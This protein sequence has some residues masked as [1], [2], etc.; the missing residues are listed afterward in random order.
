MG[1]YTASVIANIMA[2][3]GAGNQTHQLQEIK[4][5]NQPRW[6]CFYKHHE[7]TGS[8]RKTISDIV[9]KRYIVQYLKARQKNWG[10]LYRTADWCISKVSKASR[11]KY[12]PHATIMK[13]VYGMAYF[14]QTHHLR[15]RV[16][17]DRADQC[18][19]CSLPETGIFHMGK[20][21]GEKQQETR[22][23][24]SA[25][26]QDV[27][28]KSS[29]TTE[30]RNSLA[31]FELLDPDDVWNNYLSGEAML[32]ADGTANFAKTVMEMGEESYRKGVWDKKM[33]GA[34]RQLGVPQEEAQSMSQ[35]LIRLHQQEI[36]ILYNNRCKQAH[37]NAQ[38]KIAKIA[39][40]RKRKVHIL[41]SKKR[42]RKKRVE[43]LGPRRGRIDS[44]FNAK[45]VSDP[46]LV[47]D[48]VPKKNTDESTGIS[49]NYDNITS[50][51][52]LDE[53]ASELQVDAASSNYSGV[54]NE[55][56]PQSGRADSMQEIWREDCQINDSDM[57]SSKQGNTD[58]VSTTC[59]F[60]DPI[61]FSPADLDDVERNVAPTNKS[62]KD[63]SDFEAASKPTC[64][65]LTAEQRQRQ[66]TR[67]QSTSEGKQKTG[68]HSVKGHLM[69]WSGS[70]EK[71][72]DH[73]LETERAT[74][75]AKGKKRR[76]LANS[77]DGLQ[78]NETHNVAEKGSSTANGFQD[79][80]PRK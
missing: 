22:I 4:L 52:S 47:N 63:V 25:R 34:I 75:E 68:L 49:E 41:P 45:M 53:N 62:V 6:R 38:K 11:P 65:D 33:V 59:G 19:F 37:A 66:E 80:V 5:W 17:A 42:K 76:R 24:M 55:E 56:L 73:I 69:H 46:M 20:C 70:F 12:S 2:D 50:D 58:T 36:S 28:L 74:Y 10:S 27:W 31:D 78:L 7:I 15:G 60:Q 67:Q 16:D 43:P 23:L 9:R 26:K 18:P 48:I 39:K 14:R 21:S 1:E 32:V 44:F 40:R 72:Q 64:S 13:L 51:D 8:I 3:K 30:L 79:R 77:K 54:S 35:K 29:L 71:R 57:L 61:I